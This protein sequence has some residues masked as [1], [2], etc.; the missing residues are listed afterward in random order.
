MFTSKSLLCLLATVLAAPS[1]AYSLG[2]PP[3]GAVCRSGAPRA[4]ASTSAPFETQLKQF[5]PVTDLP[6]IRNQVAKLEV[7][8]TDAVLGQ[9]FTVAA[10]LRDDLSELRSKDP[11]F[12][13]SDLRGQLNAMVEREAYIQAAATRDQ[14]MVLRRFQPQYL[15]AGLWKGAPAAQLRSGPAWLAAD[16][17]RTRRSGT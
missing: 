11:A 6:N 15:L 3:L 2:A 13:A 7:D 10:M 9:D 17:C 12:L 8:L 5:A 1:A 14:L 4:M 16:Q